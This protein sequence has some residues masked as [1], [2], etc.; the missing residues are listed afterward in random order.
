MKKNLHIPGKLLKRLPHYHYCLG[1]MAKRNRDYV[2]SEHLATDLGLSIKQVQEDLENLHESLSISDIHS[3]ESLLSI[4]E[5][6]MG[7]DQVNT[8]VLAGAGNLGL[9]LLGY[10][11][12]R[13]YGL[14]IK[15]AFDSDDQLIGKKVDEI[16]IYSIDRLEEILAIHGVEIGIITTPPEPAQQIVDRMIDAGIKGIWNFTQARI[17]IPCD[18]ELKNTSIYSDYLSLSHKVKT[19]QQTQSI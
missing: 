18:T 19:T 16:E 8:A 12:F 2:S 7:Y 13:I 9:A 14:D 4:V 1:Q 6:N 15:A 5:T 17:K 11:G 3:V 10:P